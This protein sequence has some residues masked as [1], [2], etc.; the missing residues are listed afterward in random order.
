[1]SRTRRQRRRRRRAVDGSPRGG[2]TVVTAPARRLRIRIAGGL[3]ALGTVLG[4]LVAGTSLYDWLEDRLDAREAAPPP[5]I[6]ARIS[7]T[8]LTKMREP[9]EDYLRSV[10]G[11]TKGLTKAE[12]QEQGLVF[13]TRVH[14]KGSQGQRY[15]LRLSLFN[16]KTRRQLQD[17]IYTQTVVDYTTAAQDH[18]RSW[19]SWFPYPLRL[20]TYFARATLLDAKQQPVDEQDSKALPVTYIPPLPDV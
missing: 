9:Q 13:T 5:K 3:A 17:P 4:L 14:L 12:L 2:S 20:G 15:S 19:P 10:G 16:V 6:D 1:M 11:S 7:S 18:A 8:G